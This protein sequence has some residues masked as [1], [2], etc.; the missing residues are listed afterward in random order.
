MFDGF[1]WGAV[2]TCRFVVSHA[3]DCFVELFAVFG[4]RWSGIWTAYLVIS[5]LVAANLTFRNSNQRAAAPLDESR[6]F[7]FPS[8]EMFW[9][10]G[11]GF[12]T[13][14]STIEKTLCVLFVA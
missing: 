9:D 13:N 11:L 3:P 1:Y 6:I 12:L 4:D 2:R 5:L 10:G 7:P 14:F 8:V